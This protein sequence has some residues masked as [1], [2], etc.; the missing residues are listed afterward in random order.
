MPQLRPPVDD[1]ESV[2]ESADDHPPAAGAYPVAMIEVQ[3]RVVIARPVD[4]VLEFVMDI[5]RYQQV[6]T[7]IKPVEQ[8]TRTPT[9]TEFHF[10]PK[11]G[12][13]RMPGP[14]TGSSMQLTAG[15]RWGAACW[16]SVVRFLFMAL[17]CESTA[18]K[19]DVTTP[20]ELDRT[21]SP[22]LLLFSLI[23]T[24]TVGSGVTPDLL[25]CPATR[26]RAALAGYVQVRTYR[27]WGVSPRP[28]NAPRYM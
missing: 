27:R 22:C 1:P 10:H 15:A 8:V 11:L 6:D 17:L 7:K 4:E 14:T 18:R 23:R 19:Q 9:R 16:T 26:S 2:T 12:G 21:A 3:R 13:I 25:T 28:E 5:E 24:M 20:A